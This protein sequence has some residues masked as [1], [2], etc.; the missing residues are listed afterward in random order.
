MPTRPEG[1]ADHSFPSKPFG[2][3]RDAPRK[4]QKLKNKNRNSLAKLA[5]IAKK[6][7][8]FGKTLY[9]DILEKDGAFFSSPFDKQTQLGQFW[10]ETFSLKSI[11]LAKAELYL[12]RFS[13]VFF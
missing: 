10:A 4:K 3:R 6:W 13:F 12:S 8:P 1:S 7:T 5:R 11:D 2:K 9:L